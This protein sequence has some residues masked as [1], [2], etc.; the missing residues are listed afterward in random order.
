MSLTHSQIAQTAG[1]FLEVLG[2]LGLPGTGIAR[3][4]IKGIESVCTSREAQEK[5]TRLLEQAEEE[6]LKEARQQG[7]KNAS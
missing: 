6:F 5:L 3:L 7:M 1:I 2:D 4:A